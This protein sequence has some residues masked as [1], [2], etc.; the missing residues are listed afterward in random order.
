MRIV[1][2]TDNLNCIRVTNLLTA[3]LI[4]VLASACALP[5]FSQT[6]FASE[7]IDL[8][9]VDQLSVGLP[10]LKHI[11]DVHR[12]A[13]EKQKGRCVL[14]EADI[15]RG[16]S[17]NKLLIFRGE[18]R[19]FES[20]ATSSFARWIAATSE[21]A[22]RFSSN[23]ALSHFLF[24]LMRID[25]GPNNFFD[26][27][28]RAFDNASSTPRSK[29]RVLASNHLSLEG[30]KIIDPAAN[31]TFVF[32]PFVS[33]SLNP[34]LALEYTRDRGSFNAEA[35]LFVAAVPKEK[36]ISLAGQECDRD[37]ELDSSMIYDIN[38]CARGDGAS[39]SDQE[40]DAAF[41]LP[42]QYLR[43]AVRFNRDK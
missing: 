1:D 34:H 43:W 30:L 31:E 5:A 12:Q 39:D 8:E 14:T 27:K 41:Y 22:R 25:L 19:L 18:R 10:F 24:S 15:V 21:L 35:V 28:R 3:W 32:D 20:P 6:Q 4:F 37:L 42:R 17:A 16:G 9:A 11:E 38:K 13:C 23:R 7:K 33:F 36:F 26:A 29:L 40:R 2:N